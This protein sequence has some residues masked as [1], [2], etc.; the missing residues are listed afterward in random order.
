MRLARNA[1]AAHS[2]RRRLATALGGGDPLGGRRLAFIHLPRTGGTAVQ[3]HLE[4]TAGKAN[5]ARVGLPDDFF[6]QL[7]VLR[8]SPIVVG[9][10]F[11]PVVGLIDGAAV[12]TVV[13]DPVERS[14]S[15]WEHP[16]WHPGH[17]D[18]EVIAAREIRTI[19]DFANDIHLGG[20]IRNNQTRFLGLDYDLEAI[21]AELE[22]GAIDHRRAVHLAAEAQFAEADREMLERAKRR[23]ERM[24]L[25][26]V[27]EE[28]PAFTREL[29]GRIGL[30][31]GPE[32]PA[33]NA[34]PP[35]L[36]ENRAAA[37]DDATR[38][39]LAELN[40]LDAELHTF[41]RE[42]WAAHRARA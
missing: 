26:G 18:R 36:V 15:V 9:H 35:E 37:Y 25:V 16:R 8:S 7:A 39:R 22:S 32:L 12:A 28:L 2:W 5:V 13:R 19:E 31:P 6:E 40:S 3:H 17:P 23:L 34:S 10:F 1:K 41:A 24:L 33:V 29:E 11:Y 42:L 21:V 30:R 27:T 4:A 38:R 14:I 20:H